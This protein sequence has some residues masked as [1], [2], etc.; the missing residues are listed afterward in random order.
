MFKHYSVMSCLAL[1]AKTH[2]V[3]LLW[4][5]SKGNFHVFH[6]VIQML[7]LDENAVFVR[8]EQ[9]VDVMML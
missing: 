7:K 9:R 8:F 1:P 6:G 5:H 2:F 4:F 3:F